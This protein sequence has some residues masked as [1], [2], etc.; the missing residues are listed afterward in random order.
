MTTAL[1]DDVDRVFQMPT[2]FSAGFMKYPR[3]AERRMFGIVTECIGHPGAGGANAFG[4]PENRVSFAYVMNQMEQQILPNEKSLRS[5]RMRFTC[6]TPI[7]Q[8]ASFQ[9]YGGTRSTYSPTLVTSIFRR[10]LRDDVRRGK[11]PA[12]FQAAFCH[13]QWVPSRWC[14]SGPCEYVMACR[15]CLRSCV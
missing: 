1:A 13:R 9:R 15:R 6:K 2:A 3:N 12:R 10:A 7:L 14:A 4:D 8:R 11:C 5:G